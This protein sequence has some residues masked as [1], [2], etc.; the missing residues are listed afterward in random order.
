MVIIIV[1]AVEGWYTCDHAYDLRQTP[2]VPHCFPSYQAYDHAADY[3]FAGLWRLVLAGHVDVLGLVFVEVITTARFS[4]VVW[5]PT[6]R[7]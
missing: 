5:P 1:F 4:Q 2:N 6:P 3:T 7:S